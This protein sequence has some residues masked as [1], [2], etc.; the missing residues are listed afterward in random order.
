MSVTFQSTTG[1]NPSCLAMR[2][3][4]APCPCALSTTVAGGAAPLLSWC[5][6]HCGQAIGTFQR[7]PY[8]NAAAA[9]PITCTYV[10]P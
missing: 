5:C 10:W 1:C 6:P 7:T 3:H 8:S 4:V 2:M 9:N